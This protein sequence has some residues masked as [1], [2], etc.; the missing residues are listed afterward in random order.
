MDMSERVTWESCPRCGARAAVGWV[1]ET[2]AE[3]DCTMECELSEEHVD[4][5]RLRSTPPARVVH[6]EP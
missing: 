3:V 4:E 1:D 6:G 5:I 2:V